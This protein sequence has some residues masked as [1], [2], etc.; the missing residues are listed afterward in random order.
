NIDTGSGNVNGSGVQADALMVDTGS[1][2]VEIALTTATRDIEV[3]TG[4]GDVTITVPDGL[5]AEVTLET[6][7]GSI[8]VDFAIQI[9]RWERDEV[10]G[11]IGNGSGRIHIDTGSGDI[12]IRKQ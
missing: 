4:S 7:S 12:T 2:D 1:G 10:R 9:Q 8:E 11:V 6:S 5:D 3:D